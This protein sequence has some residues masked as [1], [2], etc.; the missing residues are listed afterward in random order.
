ME[1]IAIIGAGSAGLAIAADLGSRGFPLGALAE[2]DPARLAAMTEAGAIRASGL[3]GSIELPMPPVS[4]TL[5]AV[6]GCRWIFVATTADTHMRV[7]AALQGHVSERHT[8]V[9]VTG[10]VGG[11]A[12]V[13]E[14]LRRGCR[15]GAAARVI[16]L[17]TSP[18]LSCSTRGGVVHI[19]A[20]KDWVEATSATDAVDDID[21][22]QALLPA[23][24]PGADA[25]ASALNNQ[26]PIAHVPTYLCNVAEATSGRLVGPDESRGGA[27]YL[28][29]YTSD[30]VLKIR[31]AADA[32]RLAVMRA[33]GLGDQAISRADFLARAYRPGSRE[34]APPRMGRTFQARFIS[35]DVPCGLV[36]LEA[37][38]AAHAVK[39]PTI[40]GLIT[41]AG[42]ISGTDWRANGRIVPQNQPGKY[43]YRA[44]ETGPRAGA[45]R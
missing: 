10:Y 35:E 16:E 34:A 8:I 18:H 3:L 31:L 40:S 28:E 21:E 9:L 33:M 43:M 6:A 27:F 12:L 11:S 5:E 22:L 20:R 39:V 4:A 45:A 38:A 29:D 37:L 19:A 41:L 2:S 13:S 30:A 17:N 7:A 24:V 14:V 15:G 25:L 36:P 32:E 42:A 44:K 26:N 23:V 1:R